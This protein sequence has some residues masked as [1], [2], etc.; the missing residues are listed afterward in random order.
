MRL[1][2]KSSEKSMKLLTIDK[3]RH[4]NIK[5]APLTYFYEVGQ[6]LYT[7][8][9]LHTMN[10]KKQSKEHA[11][12]R[13]LK[14][15]LRTTTKGVGYVIVEDNDEDIEIEPSFLNTG[16]NG[17]EVQVLLHPKVPGKRTTGEITK[18]IL[19]AKMEFVGTLEGGK[20]KG[21]FFLDPQD[22]KMYVD[23]FI[24]GSKA[25]DA[26]SGEKALVKIV[27]WDN[28]K[29]NPEGEVIKV[30]GQPGDNNV[31]MEA[32]V[33]DKGLRISFPDE[34]EKAAREIVLDAKNNIA[35]E[36]EKRRDMRN[37]TTFTIDPE[38]AKDF[39]DALS[40]E[41]LP[42][43]NIEVGI[44]IADVTHYVTP[45]GDIDKA[46]I[47]RATSIYLVDRTIP[48]LPEALSNN[49]C[50]LM[51]EVERL[52]F[53]AIFTFNK[54]SFNEG[55]KPEIINQWFGETVI[56]S[57]KRFSYEDAQ[58]ILD[59]K[60]GLFYH[61]LNTLNN[62]SKKIRE[63]K[64]AAGAMSF[65]TDE[66]KFVL[67]KS[68]K[69][70]DIMR[71][72]RGDTHKMIE[73]FMLLANRKVAEYASKKTG[74]KKGQFVYRIH[75]K[76]ETERIE[77]LAAL[78]N[79]LGYNLKIKD[80]EVSSKDL[81]EILLQA[82][83]TAEENLIQTATIRSMAKAI[84]STK[85][86]GHYSL[87]FKYYTNFT[88]PIRRYPDMMVHRLMKYYLAG[89][90]VP[91]DMLEQYDTLSIHSS[92]M[93]KV[94]SEAERGSIKYK[95]VEYMTERVGKTFP[96]VIS[97]VTEWGI[98]VEEEHSKSEGMV[99]LRDLEDDYYTFNEKTRTITGERHKRKYRLGDKV[100]IKVKNADLKRRI[101]D[102][103]FV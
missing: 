93:E 69:P 19:R 23:I 11:S 50:S 47:R 59:D 2:Q 78:L 98:Y 46:A 43:G 58:K 82:E 55:G 87:A 41:E 32:I 26:K 18:I 81:N 49:I 64:F 70:I 95:Q 38:T 53:S 14:G 80:G 61:E 20:G 16:L 45:G 36:I 68:G 73:D 31:E 99:R 44:H 94:A 34:V 101:I 84:Y 10:L 71:K 6:F 67:D 102:Y 96:G 90:K 75:P 77:S 25:K 13:F 97:G 28:C 40:F 1:D 39:D 15:I 76:P 60:K 103:V 79:S 92:E 85:N 29:K 66:V 88:S 89:G 57:D 35:R 74:G 56:K 9:I 62:L 5:T 24:P 65:E 42:D 21:F 100:K 3:P 63:E 7:C 30:L 37:I 48:M 8:D 51:P 27:E 22:P 54:G 4:T 86:V 33:L 17:D 72:E 12:E 83:G 91:L 52:A